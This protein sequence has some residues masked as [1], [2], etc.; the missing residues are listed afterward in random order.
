MRADFFRMYPY[1][2]NSAGCEE[3]VCIIPRKNPLKNKVSFAICFKTKQPP[4]LFERA[5]EDPFL[6]EL[7]VARRPRLAYLDV[8]LEPEEQY[9]LSYHHC[10]GS[11]L[12]L[13]IASCLD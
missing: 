5:R 11:I 4:S 2:L 9:A 8:A 10:V 13:R 7:L 12:S 1:P 3:P 6:F